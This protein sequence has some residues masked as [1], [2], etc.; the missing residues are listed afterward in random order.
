MKRPRRDGLAKSTG[1]HFTPPALARFVARRIA[2]VCAATAPTVID[3]ACGDGELLLAFAAERPNASLIGFDLDPHAL[4]AAAQRISGRLEEKN[5]LD[6]A[7]LHRQD[8]LFNQPE[9][10]K[11]DAAIANPPYIRTQVLG[12]LRA[13]QLAEQFHLAGRVD[14]YFAFIEGIAE[15][16]K[17]GGIAGIIVSNRFMTTVAG[18]TVRERILEKFDVL[19]VWDL[20]DTKLFEAAVLPAVLILR[21]KDGRPAPE[22]RMSSIYTSQAAAQVRADSA[23]D[24]LELEGFVAVGDLVFNVQHGVLNHGHNVWRIGTASGDQWL[25][26]VRARTFCTFGDIGKIRVGIKTTADK[27]FVRKIWPEPRPE[28]LRPLVAHDVGRRYRSLPPDREILYTHE[29]REG[30]RVPVDL[31]KFP[32]SKAY[33]ES[34][35]DAL[36]SRTYVLKANRQWFEIWVPHQPKLWKRP[37]LVFPDISEKPN[38]WMSLDDELVQGDCYWLAAD[39]DSQVD[40]LWLALAVANSQFIENFYDHCFNNKLY[41]GRRRFMTQYVE[42]FPIPDPESPLS[43]R[44]VKTV[45]RIFE[46]TPSEEATGLALDLED[47]VR[48]SFGEAKQPVPLRG[49]A[50]SLLQRINESQSEITISVS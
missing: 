6:V 21:K 22:P 23:L 43:K 16:L 35:R 12:A 10:V 33:L 41:S 25:D 30:R 11:Y 27:L 4:Q 7:L 31:E 28:L 24:A 18:A 3:P 47:M 37:K 38:F 17:P 42:Q 34:H 15:I 44:I 46:M 2:E 39:D 36:A 8:D 29:E 45:K 13:Q 9:C 14:I 5:F 20:G 32:L 19:H 1:S 26:T 48:R 49:S 50:N 40:L